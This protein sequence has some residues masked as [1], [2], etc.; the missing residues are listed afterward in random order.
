V[1]KDDGKPEASF[2]FEPDEAAVLSSL[3]PA[4]VETMVYHA[5]IDSAAAEQGARRKAMKS[6]TDNATEII[7]TLQRSYNRARQGQITTEISE[8]VG[9]AAA[10]KKE[11]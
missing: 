4:Y 7:N 1:A 5:L 8:I 9:G 3:L 10:L 2:D 11:E 6:A